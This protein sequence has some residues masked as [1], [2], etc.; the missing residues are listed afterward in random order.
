MLH[1]IFL[2][3]LSLV[4]LTFCEASKNPFAFLGDAAAPGAEV[5]GDARPAGD[6]PAAAAGREQRRPQ[7][8][9]QGGAPSPSKDCC[10][11]F[12]QATCWQP[13]IHFQ[14]SPIHKFVLKKR[15]QVVAPAVAPSPKNGAPAETA[16]ER[17]LFLLFEKIE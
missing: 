16:S 4:S 11:S 15:V 1:A 2:N 6:P 10:F 12:F 9:G 3:S 7:G 8:P 13:S 5:Q 14:R 17:Q